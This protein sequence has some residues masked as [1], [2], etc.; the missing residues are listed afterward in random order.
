MRGK[1]DGIFKLNKKIKIYYKTKQ[2]INKHPIGV[3]EKEREKRELWCAAF[4]SDSLA[5]IMAIHY[6][7]RVGFRHLDLVSLIR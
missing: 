3:K 7:C 5:Q 1:D 4:R 6:A 2:V